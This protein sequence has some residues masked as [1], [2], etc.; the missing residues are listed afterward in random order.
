MTKTEFEVYPKSFTVNN[1]ILQDDGRYMATIPAATHGLGTNYH[2]DK[3][4]RRDDDLN[5]QN[6]LAVYRILSN[7]DFEY[8][9]DEPCVCKV[10]L[11]GE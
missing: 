4:L 3:M 1:F 6:M 8:Y 11:V 5:W 7:G 2:V 10:Y 9:V